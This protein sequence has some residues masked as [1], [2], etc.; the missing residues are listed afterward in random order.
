MD[1]PN[2]TIPHRKP[3]VATERQLDYIE[4]LL[5]KLDADLSAY[6]GTPAFQLT[7]K[8]A[9]DLIDALKED[10]TAYDLWDDD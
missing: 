2:T 10:V 5:D 4:S 8:E 7:S 1:F 9:S 6:T 3:T